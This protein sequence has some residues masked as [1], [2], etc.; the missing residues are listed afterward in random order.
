M[1]E[2]IH[3]SGHHRD[4]VEHLFAHGHSIEWNKAL[5]LIQAVGKAEE[6]H[7]GK[8]QVAIG[9]E[10]ETFDR[11]KDGMLSLHQM[12][13]LRRMFSHAGFG[14]QGASGI[15]SDVPP[16][17]LNGKQVVMAMDFHRTR[18]W[19]TDAVRGAAPTVLI[20]YDL[21]GYFHHVAHF[22]ENPR[23]VYEADSPEYWRHLTELLAGVNEALVIS[24]G[25]GKARASQHFLDYARAHRADL[26]SKVVADLRADVDDL[27]DAQ[28]LRLAQDFFDI[29]PSRDLGDERRGVAPGRS[30]GGESET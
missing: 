20:P 11:P 17:S 27:S 19:A 23:G 1:T 28:I 13:D 12:V 18:V 30:S 4:T 7:N 26:A 5:S 10:S 25:K 29:E 2:A 21:H 14:P 9:S 22:R 3:L 8:W 6:K 16:P 15:V 24:H